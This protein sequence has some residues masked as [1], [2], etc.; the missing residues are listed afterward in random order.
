MPK[1]YLSLSIFKWDSVFNLHVFATK[2]I[3]NEMLHTGHTS[4]KTLLTF[5][6]VSCVL[7]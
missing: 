4:V 5:Y 3:L 1:R 7:K 6:C 2:L